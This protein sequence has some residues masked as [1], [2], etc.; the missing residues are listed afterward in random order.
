MTESNSFLS[1]KLDTFSTELRQKTPIPRQVAAFVHGLIVTGELKP[2]ERIIESRLAKR[3]G[4]GHPTV[5]EALV[6]LEHQGLVVRRANQGCVVTTLSHHEIRHILDVR[7]VL[8][9]YAIELAVGR[10][11]PS[12]IEELLAVAGQ[13]R[14]AGV[15]SDIEAFYKCDLLFHETLWKLADNPFLFKSLTQLMVPLLA[16]CMLKNLRD[17]AY[18][19]MAKSADAH[20]EITRAI[21]S[22][23][24]EFAKKVARQTLAVFANQ[25]LRDYSAPVDGV[26]QALRR[27]DWGSEVR[28]EG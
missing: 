6:A 1:A 2:G 12:D 23:D 18:L 26:A 25:H 17:H 22:G 24:K 7:V 14:A 19:D 28:A 10:T 8:E 15:A 5:R 16:F 13:M 9:T 4:I 21:E 11:R 3:L 27:P 20:V